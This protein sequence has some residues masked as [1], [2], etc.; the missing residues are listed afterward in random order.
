[1]Q[2]AICRRPLYILAIQI[3]R[4]YIGPKCAKKAGI[5]V[6]EK[7]NIKRVKLGGT[8]PSHKDT[9]T[10]DLFEGAEP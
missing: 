3:G 9:Q 10:L 1:M 6:N 5:K 8:V 7:L 4:E 2:C